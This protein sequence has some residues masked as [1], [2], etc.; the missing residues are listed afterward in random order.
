MI[1]SSR[2][3]PLPIPAHHLTTGAIT[4]YEL[5]NTNSLSTDCVSLCH[6]F[7]APLPAN[8]FYPF[9][10]FHSF[11]K[12]Y[13]LPRLKCL[14]PGFSMHRFQLPNVPQLPWNPSKKASCDPSTPCL[15]LSWT[16][17]S[18]FHCPP[19]STLDDI[20][21][22][23]C[24]LNSLR[25]PSKAHPKLSC[26]IP[27]HRECVLLSPLATVLTQHTPKSA[28]HAHGTHPPRS[29]AWG[30]F[31]APGFFTHIK[32]TVATKE[33]ENCFSLSIQNFK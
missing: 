18:H 32:H 28:G 31:Y 17:E 23:R 6:Y 1:P 16:P 9:L 33:F 30:P 4:A 8:P 19:N 12:C 21:V 14:T 25:L 24:Q 7:P 10:P 29:G 22:L 15:I 2:L 26:T 3:S 13:I 11:K 20:L 5:S 27:A